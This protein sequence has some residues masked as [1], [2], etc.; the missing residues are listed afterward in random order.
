[1]GYPNFAQIWDGHAFKPLNLLNM[2]A[3]R[4]LNP[5]TGFFWFRQVL[6]VA[7][8]LFVTRYGFQLRLS[9]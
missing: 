4:N 1:M 3:R 5:M 9:D 2:K 6:F 7:A 8:A